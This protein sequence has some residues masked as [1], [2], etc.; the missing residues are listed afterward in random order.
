MPALWRC[1][2]ANAGAASTHAQFAQT[3]DFK[4]SK[5]IIKNFR[6]SFVIV[7]G[8]QCSLGALEQHTNKLISSQR[9]GT[10]HATSVFVLVFPLHVY[11]T[12]SPPLELFT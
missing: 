3:D 2:G 9:H 11:Y 6:G 12:F 8:A 1:A 4:Y 5:I 7:P 10:C